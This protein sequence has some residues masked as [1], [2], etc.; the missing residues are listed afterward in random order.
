M[1]AVD[2]GR[3]ASA[4]PAGDAGDG[5]VVPPARRRARSRTPRAS[6]CASR[7]SEDRD[8][9][10]TRG[11][12]TGSA[13]RHAP[14]ERSRSGCGSDRSSRQTGAA[15]GA[16]ALQHRAAGPGAHPST[17]AVLLGTALVVGLKRTLHVVLLVT[18]PTQF[19]RVPRLSRSLVARRCRTTRPDK[20]TGPGPVAATGGGQTTTG[21]YAARRRPHRAGSRRRVRRFRRSRD[22]ASLQRL[23]Y[24]C[25]HLWT[26]VWTN[27]VAT[28]TTERRG[29]VTRV[30]GR[31]TA[32]RD[33]APTGTHPH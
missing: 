2:R 6:R 10:C 5:C 16:T 28:T 22:R 32:W 18:R 17:E 14:D 27:G 11:P 33:A 24:G 4:A 13:C 3:S 1:G 15:L 25:P 31:R 7:S 26:T 21:Q 20:A 30:C 29:P 19:G 9:R 12:N 8:T 23:P